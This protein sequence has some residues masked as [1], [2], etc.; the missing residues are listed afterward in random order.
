MKKFLSDHRG[1]RT[2]CL[3]LCCLSLVVLDLAIRSVY[4]FLGDTGLLDWRP[5]LFTLLWTLLFTAL[6]SLL[7][8]WGRRGA[9]LALEL[10]FVILCVTHGTLYNVTGRLFTFSDMS[11]AGDGAK[12]FSWSY[13]RMRKLY[14]L[15]LLLS[16]L[17]MGAAVA[18]AGCPPKRKRTWKC[19]VCALVLAAVCGAGLGAVH[20]ACMPKGDVLR[21][22]GVYALDSREE[23]YREFTNSGRCMAMTGL[24]QYTLRDLAISRGWV[25]DVQSVEKLDDYFEERSR[26]ISGENE[27]TGVLEGK[28]LIM[29]MMESIDT[30]LVTEDYMPNLW[31]LRQT[32]VD[33]C[34]FYTPLYLSA[35]TFNTEIITQTGLIPAASGLSGAAY[36]TNSFPLSLANQFR[37]KGYSANSFHSASPDI[38]NRGAVHENLGFEA[39]HFFA[40]M[41]MEDYQLD[42]QMLGGYDQMVAGAPFY[43][44]IITYSGHGPYNEEMG[45]IAAPHYEEAKAAVAASGV[46]GSQENMEEYTRAVAHA[47]ETDEWIG[48]LVD[49]LRQDGH[50]TED[51]GGDTVLLLYADHYG[52]YMSDKDFLKELKGVTAEDPAELYHTPC[53]LYGGGLAAQKVDKVCS[54]VDLVPTLANLFRLDADRTYYFGDDIF[55]DRG[56]TVFLPN[57]WYDGAICY[58]ASYQ[59]QVTEEMKARSE[60]V[61]KR[62]KASGDALKCDYFKKRE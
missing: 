2:L 52:K 43:T 34:R 45:N 4:G 56:G 41:G 50:L 42:S 23:S 30:W 59:G 37:D 7:P 18:L 32:G 60:E 20:R 54:S 31:Q 9:M 6:I 13:L 39:Y 33:F 22:D 26:E 1:L 44:Y 62:V 25:G 21:W 58:T 28:N 53:V 38:Y 35:G 17:M 24:Y 40:D 3:P 61:S 57:G 29:V 11:F 48:G 49:R 10:L 46:T 12:F 14:L 5:C 8:K 51:G 55:G 16:V 47:M 27:M 15:L 36:M 19:R